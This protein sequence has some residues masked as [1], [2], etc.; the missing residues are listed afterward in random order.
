MAHR[1]NRTLHIMAV[2]QLRN[3]TEG[4]AH[5]DAKKTAGKTS[6]EAMRALKRRLSN[7]AYA[8]M[9]ADQK[10][11]QVAGPGGHSGTTLQS[12]VTDLTPDIGPS[13]KPLPGPA[14]N[15]PRPLASA[16]P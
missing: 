16:A 7:V 14:T 5:F 11:R 12:S 13:D 3:R 6:I 8:R 9:I 15:Q 2:V 1:I 4:R 10:R